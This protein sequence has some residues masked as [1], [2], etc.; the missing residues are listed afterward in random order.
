MRY[1]AQLAQ[2]V[3][4][5][6]SGAAWIHE[7]KL[8]GYRIAVAK[9]GAS[10]ELISRR[11]TKWTA[12]FPKLAAS[13]KKLRAGSALVDGEIVMLSAS[14]VSSFEALQNRGRPLVGSGG[15]CDDDDHAAHMDMADMSMPGMPMSGDGANGS[16]DSHSGCSLPW[17]PAQCQS[18]TS[19]AP[20]AMAVEQPAVVANVIVARVSGWPREPWPPFPA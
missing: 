4:Q 16:T 14:G 6:P 12:D 20:S 10:V 15:R 2:L 5:P 3:S 19:C 18:M 9:D 17:S 13:A 1:S 7:L 8:D 11:G